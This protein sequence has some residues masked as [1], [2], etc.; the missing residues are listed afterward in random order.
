LAEGSPRIRALNLMKNFGQHNAI[1][2]G[3]HEASGEYI[4]FMD[5]DGQHDP[6]YIRPM[7]EKIRQ[8]YDVVYTKYEEKAYG[9]FKN[10]GSKINDVMSTWL[11]EKPADLYLCSFKVVTRKV[12]DQIIK[13]PGPY[14]Y[15]DGTIFTSTRNV[16][17]IPAKHRGTEKDASTYSLRKLIR[18]WL[19]MFTNFSVKPLRMIFFLGFFIG[20][21]SFLLVAVLAA[22]RIINPSWTPPGWTMTAALILFFGAIQL[23]SLGLV[24]EYIGRILLFINKRP[25]F[26]VRDR[27]SRNE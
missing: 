4:V 9:L 18:H 24:G 21:G 23:I 6:A 12:R 20:L 11:L 27:V 1:M 26:V 14:P 2:A 17:A 15:I 19:N 13:Y 8:G 3:L 10:L 7:I 22:L 16:A 5:D 25:Q